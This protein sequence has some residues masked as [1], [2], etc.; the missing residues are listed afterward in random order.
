MVKYTVTFLD[1]TAVP[2]VMVYA[3]A[4]SNIVFDHTAEDDVVVQD[5]GVSLYNAP[6]PEDFAVFEQEL[7]KLGLAVA[8]A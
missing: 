4:I 2:N 5:G 3:A 6:A 7:A 8:E 1:G